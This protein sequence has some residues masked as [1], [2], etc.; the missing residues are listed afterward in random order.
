M[1]LKDLK[2]QVKT[3]GQP[4]LAFQ[5]AYSRSGYKA[6]ITFCISHK[7]TYLHG[8]FCSLQ[9]CDCP[10]QYFSM[11][12]LLNYHERNVTC[13]GLYSLCSLFV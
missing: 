7:D 9:S 4:N 13:Q 1:I 12:V 6:K 11:K 2:L 10:I 3:T 5:K 8:D